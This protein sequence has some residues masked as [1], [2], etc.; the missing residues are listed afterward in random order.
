MLERNRKFGIVWKI[1]EEKTR[2]MTESTINLSK[3]NV[4]VP[5]YPYKKSSNSSLLPF[6]A[7]TYMTV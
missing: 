4:E 1:E 6:F 7:H 3:G 5:L 2:E